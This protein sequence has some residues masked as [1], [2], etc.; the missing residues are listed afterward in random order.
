MASNSN[1]TPPTQWRWDRFDAKQVTSVARASR[2][3]VGKDCN[4]LSTHQAMQR[5]VLLQDKKAA[6]L[7][8]IAGELHK[9]LH[10]AANIVGMT[11]RCK[12]TQHKLT[13]HTLPCI[14][15]KDIRLAWMQDGG[16]DNMQRLAWMFYFYG[17]EIHGRGR[18]TLSHGEWV[19]QKVMTLLNVLYVHLR[20]LPIGQRTCVHQLY[21]KKF[22]DIRTNIM[23][24]N[25]SFTHKSMMTKEQQKKSSLFTKNFKRNKNTFFVILDIENNTEWRKASR[26][27]A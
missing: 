4:L 2:S 16:E 21:S 8:I 3:C 15:S 24:R 10:D 27:W 17:T 13:Q 26:P 23:R 11:Y 14:N 7:H 6:S 22:N 25:G 18:S 5:R 20:E 12:L 9:L 19:E 1:E